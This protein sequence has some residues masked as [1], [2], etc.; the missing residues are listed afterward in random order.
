M[1]HVG[2]VANWNVFFF[3][4]YRPVSSHI[5]SSKEANIKLAHLSQPVFLT[6]TVSNQL[7]ETQSSVS[8]T[9]RATAFPPGRLSCTGSLLTLPSTTPLMSLGF[10][11]TPKMINRPRQSSPIRLQNSSRSIKSTSLPG[12]PL[13]PGFWM[14][15]VTRLRFPRRQRRHLQSLYCQLKPY[16]LSDPQKVRVQSPQTVRL[17]A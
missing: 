3:S 12:R 4:S 16:F 13:C 8:R 1:I 11:G 10:P 14:G 5:P 9:T 2:E 6:H 7:M 17:G 15:E